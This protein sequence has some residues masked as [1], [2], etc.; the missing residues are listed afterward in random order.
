MSH[1]NRHSP[2]EV[3]RNL[4]NT[5]NRFTQEIDFEFSK[6]PTWHKNHSGRKIVSILY[7]KTVADDI[8]WIGKGMKTCMQRFWL[9]FEVSDSKIYYIN[10]SY[11]IAF[12]NLENIVEIRM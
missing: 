7:R 11:S 9:D 3:K 12:L 10:K 4:H 8:E 2:I 6:L 5:T 1:P